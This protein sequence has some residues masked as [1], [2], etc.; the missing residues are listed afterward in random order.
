LQELV[1][2]EKEEGQDEAEKED[3][4]GLLDHSGVLA[5]ALHPPLGMEEYGKLSIGT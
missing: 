3:L 1:A 5:G 2:K 4:Q